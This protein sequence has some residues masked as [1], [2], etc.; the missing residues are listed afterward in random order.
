MNLKLQL[1]E[2][3]Y[4]LQKAYDLAFEHLPSSPMSISVKPKELGK[5][6][7]FDFN[8]I[9]RIMQELISDGYVT[10][11]LGMGSLLITHQG[12]K[13]LREIEGEFPIS[14]TEFGEVQTTNTK[15][16]TQTNMKQS[17]K[18]DL[19]LRELYNYKNDGK[20]YSID[21]ICQKL[22]IPLDSDLELRNIAKR[23]EDDGYIKMLCSRFDCDAEL[24]S[25]GVDYCEEDSY[26][27]KGHPLI[28]N[29]YNVSIVNSPNSNIVNQSS[30]VTINQSISEVNH[31]IEKI[32]E[33]ITAD[34]TV[35]EFKANEI[36]EC[37][38]EIQES[39]NNKKKPK[40][41]IKSLLD[42]AGGI[43]S[44]SSWLAVL[45]QYAEIIPLP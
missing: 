21:L 7:G 17:E 36:L 31:A 44:I 42:I 33:T 15:K 39:V 18:F 32:K 29:N 23:L 4:F 45:G 38:H 14:T 34:N 13:Y 35:E 40:F 20:Y 11:T 12:I 19:I 16:S 24:T 8:Q 9:K 30:D 28:T 2:K 22:I 41:A 3:I 5:S 26:A 27:Y 25:Y 43:S 1:K 37:L 10:S 6:L